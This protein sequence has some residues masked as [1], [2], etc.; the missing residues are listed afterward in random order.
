MILVRNVFQLKFGKAREAKALVKENE[1]LHKK[2]GG[3]SSVRFL[4]D[5]T[6]QYYTFVME[7]TYENLAAFEKSSAEVMSV[8]EFGEWYQKFTPLVESGHREVFSIV[9]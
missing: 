1:T 6:G 9:S 2:Y 8:K 5:V 7:T 4:T 3:G